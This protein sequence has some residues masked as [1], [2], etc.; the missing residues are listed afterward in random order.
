MEEQEY[1]KLVDSCSFL[2]V[3]IISEHSDMAVECVKLGAQDYLFKP[4]YNGGT[5]TRAL[6]YAVQRDYL[7]K[8]YQRE[9]GISKM[10][11]DVAAVMLL[12][13]DADQT[14]SM[15]NK[16][17]GELLECSEKSIGT[18]IFSNNFMGLISSDS[19]IVK[20][21]QS[22]RRTTSS[23]A[24]PKSKCS[25]PLLPCV[26]ITIK[27]IPFFEEYSRIAG[28]VRIWGELLISWNG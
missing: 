25:I 22:A 3:V 24:L 27:S 15:I 12:V 21:G 14:V 5:L 7:T 9:R 23:A 10:Y 16:K 19:R 18:K 1:K 4:D 28:C 6:T 11:L 2:P 13:I 8:Q 17:G 26:P 20:T